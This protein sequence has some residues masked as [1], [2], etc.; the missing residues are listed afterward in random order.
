[1]EQTQ[2]EQA[3]NVTPV[4]IT[5]MHCINCAVL[6]ERRLQAVRQVR[7]V[8]VTY[9]AAYALITH[10]GQLDLAALQTALGDDGYT[11]T[12]RDP[13]QP[14]PAASTNSG[15]DYLEIAAAFLVLAGLAVLL[16]ELD[17]LPR[18]LSVSDSMSYGLVFVIGLVASVSSCLAVTGG[19]LVALAAK[20]SEA[21]PQLSDRQRLTPHLYFNAGRLDLLHAA[22]RPRRRAWLSIDAF[23]GGKRRPHG[24]RQRDYDI[25][26]A[27][28][29]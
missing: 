8:S 26:R 20:Y 24:R 10:S 3:L 18:G 13:A 12:A 29:C 25:A 22:W 1:M 14:L 19:L 23:A 7:R 15:R 17:L 11:V 4:N 21:N 16:H 2:G 9:P 27:C 5:G 28:K 6:I